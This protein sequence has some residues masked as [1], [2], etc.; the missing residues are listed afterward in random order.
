MEQTIIDLYSK[1]FS[2]RKIAAELHIS[3]TKVLRVLKKNNIPTNRGRSYYASKKT[4]QE[5]QIIELYNKG[6][7]FSQVG[8]LVGKSKSG[9]RGTLRKFN[10]NTN[11]TLGNYWCKSWDV[12]LF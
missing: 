10:I 11:R 7:S 9:V 1:D 5:E 2:S 3:K 6:Y 12:L 8:V 4:K